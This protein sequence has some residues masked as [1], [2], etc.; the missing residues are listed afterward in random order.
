MRNKWLVCLAVLLI[1][2]SWTA[3]FAGPKDQFGHGDDD[4]PELMKPKKPC[5]S[6]NLMDDL[7]LVFIWNAV[8]GMDEGKALKG[9]EQRIEQTREPAARRYPV[10][11]K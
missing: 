4:I 5:T 7:G 2:L 8:F 10:R 11:A 9:A 6:E 3:V 1:L